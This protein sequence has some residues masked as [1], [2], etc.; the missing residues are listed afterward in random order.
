MNQPA[1]TIQN[2]ESYTGKLNKQ[3]K[4]IV[5]EHLKKKSNLGKILNEVQ[6]CRTSGCLPQKSKGK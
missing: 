1:T 3:E 5:E 4:Q 2:V 6:K